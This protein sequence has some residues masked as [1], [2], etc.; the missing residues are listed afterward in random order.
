MMGGAALGVL[1]SMSNHGTGPAA[2]YT[3]IIVG[4][5]WAWLAVAYLVAVRSGSASAALRRS[6]LLLITAVVAYYATDQVYALEGITPGSAIGLDAIYWVVIAVLV[7]A[8]LAALVW[9]IHRSRLLGIVGYA[10]VPG[11]IAWDSWARGRREQ[12][13]LD[14]TNLR[15]PHNELIIEVTSLLWPIALAITAVL[16]IWQVRALRIARPSHTL[17]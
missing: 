5:P 11:F 8:V 10:I 7:S 1:S 15:L 17:S 4:S 14:E 16:I 6:L 3:S 12:R 9:L 13:L 2:Q